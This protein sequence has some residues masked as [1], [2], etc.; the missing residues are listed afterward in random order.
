MG[1]VP[2][3]RAA[4]LSMPGGATQPKT[5]VWSEWTQ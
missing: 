3:D 1:Q 2:E 4:I 5:A